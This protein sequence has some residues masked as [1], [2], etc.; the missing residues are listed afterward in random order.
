MEKDEAT[1][2]PSEDKEIPSLD[3]ESAGSSASSSELGTSSSNE[4]NTMWFILRNGK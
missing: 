1:G 4:N 3:L 2:G